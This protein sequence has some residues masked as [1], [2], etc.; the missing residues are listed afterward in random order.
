MSQWRK[1]KASDRR[2][3]LHAFQR[4]LCF[5]CQKPMRLMK[6]AAK[7]KEVIPDLCTLDHLDD[8]YSQ[9]RG[10]RPGEYRTVAACWLCN[11]NRNAKRQNDLPRQTLW[12]AS[13]AFPQELTGPVAQ[14]K[15]HRNSTPNGARSNRAGAANSSTNEGVR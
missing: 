14:R 4:G 1:R 3:K 7:M 10:N 13:G 6:P 8:R 11:N 15:E 12:S 2:A 5:W 9:E